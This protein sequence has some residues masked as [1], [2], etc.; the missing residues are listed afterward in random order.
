M[1]TVQRVVSHG[2]RAIGLALLATGCVSYEVAARP[3]GF[4]PTAARTTVSNILAHQ[5]RPGYFGNQQWVTDVEVTAD[6]VTGLIHDTGNLD[7]R[8]KRFLLRYS[9]I[10]RVT[11]EKN[12]ITRNA[13]V[14]VELGY[15]ERLRLPVGGNLE[16]ARLL[17][18]ALASLQVDALAREKPGDVAGED[19]PRPAATPTNRSPGG[20][21]ASCGHTLATGARFCPACGAARP[22]S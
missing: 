2:A 19:P 8:T 20:Y 22:G 3:T 7:G 21:C 15:G 10:A 4:S 13:W 6:H 18:D 11:A 14:N 16:D 12:R 17:A 9:R 5:A 1:S